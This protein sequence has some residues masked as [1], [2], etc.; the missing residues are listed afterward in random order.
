MDWGLGNPNK[1][2][3]LIAMLM[4][5]VWGLA[6]I[7]RW[8]FWVALAVFTALGGCLV[9]T[10]SRG[11][12]VAAFVGF[13][14]LLVL[15]PRPW[16]RHR[17]AGI[18]VAVW[19]MVAFAF[20][21]NAHERYGQGVVKQDR[22]ITNRLHLWRHGPLMIADAPNGWGL[23]NAAKSYMRWYQPL[24]D[25]EAFRTFVNSHLELL[26]EFGWPL[27]FLYIF[28]WG[29]ALL[30]CW[31]T[32]GSPWFAV[33]LGVWV[34]FGV[35]SIFSSVAESPLLWVLPMIALLT[36]VAW[37]VVKRRVPEP[38]LWALPVGA[39]T[40]GCI[41]LL[42]AGSGGTSIQGS[43]NLTVLG[44]GQPTFWLVV[45]FEG[46]LGNRF[47]HAL[48]RELMKQ[49]RPPTVAVVWAAS[50]LPSDL[51]SSVV[52]LTN[53]SP[54][55][56]TSIYRRILGNAKQTIFLSPKCHPTEAGLDAGNGSVIALF[57]E[58]STSPMLAAWEETG[59]VRRIPGAGD[60][61]PDWPNLILNEIPTL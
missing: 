61:I 31:P 40:M 4:L 16:P 9:H 59:C 19:V 37:R 34:V 35:A 45:D 30:L 54:G 39:A 28:G 48:R 44:S 2:A 53:S 27:R 55:N 41:A 17:M 50:D 23:G 33:L 56:N 20:L 57:G 10:F 32:R 14:P 47:G 11:G 25:T 58:F 36:A 13:V 12:L 29:A 60:F 6:F 7:R 24:E 43:A 1:T 22:S 38:K 15:A 5:A 26:I 46:Q 42:I 18:A 8:G 52:A 51:S 49:E 3:A 21:L